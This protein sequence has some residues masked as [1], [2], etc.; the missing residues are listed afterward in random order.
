VHVPDTA[1]VP[2]TVAEF[3]VQVPDNVPMYPASQVGTHAV[4]P[5]ACDAPQV[6]LTELRGRPVVPVVKSQVCALHV[7][8][9]VQTGLP[10]PSLVQ[11]VFNAVA[12]AV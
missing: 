4:A 5:K 10:E 2:A 7:P 12:P 1:L 11:V 3:A 8:T 6:P 9:V